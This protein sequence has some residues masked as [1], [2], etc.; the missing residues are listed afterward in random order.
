M[1][2]WQLTTWDEYRDVP[3][4]GR[5]TRL[6]EEQCR[7]LW[8]I[9]ERVRADLHE[10]ALVTM[11]MIF[12]ALAEQ[13]KSGDE[14]PFDFAVVDEAQD[15]SVAQLRFLAALAGDRPDSLF[16]S[17]DI[18]QR[19]FQ[20]QFSW[21]SVGADIRDRSTTLRLN[22][23]TSHQIRRRQISYFQLT[24]PMSTATSKIAEAPSRLSTVLS[25]R[26]RSPTRSTKR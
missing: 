22:Y 21:K 1:D 10:R 2:A 9:F 4:L 14:P 23:R 26:S 12:A 8:P 7:L 25:L 6:S 20:T 18:G 15:V 17:G 24:F 3:R 16:F 5:K 19:I 13:L 11:P